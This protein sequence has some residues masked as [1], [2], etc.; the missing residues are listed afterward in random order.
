MNKNILRGAVAVLFSVLVAMPVSAWDKKGHDITAAIAQRHLTSKAKKKICELLDGKSII[1]WAPWMDDASNSP[2]YRYSKTW[3]YFDVVNDIDSSPRAESG[4][5]LSAIPAQIATLKQKEASR[6]EKRL[7]LKFLVHLMGD[8]HQP[9]H[10]GNPEDKGGNTIKV[11]FFNRETSLHSVWDG[12]M[13]ARVHD[14]SY[15]E[16][17]DQL[18]V[19]AADSVKAISAGSIEDWVMQSH[20]VAVDICNDTP[21]GSKLSFDYA[22][23]WRETVEVQLLRGGLRLARVLN[24]IFSGK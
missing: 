6:E 1:Y 17:A 15:T 24:D 13:I 21:A 23:K 7:A 4:D 16:W 2:Q 22:A 5:I 9:L 3:H 10:I 19:L 11:N 8:L 18:D 12:S 14:W 20:E